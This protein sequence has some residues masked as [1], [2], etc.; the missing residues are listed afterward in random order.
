MSKLDEV[1]KDRIDSILGDVING[2]IDDLY[3]IF[4]NKLIK[5]NIN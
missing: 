1:I 3:T 4:D 2:N 5:I